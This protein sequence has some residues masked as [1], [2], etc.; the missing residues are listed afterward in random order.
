MLLRE[1]T[2]DLVTNYDDKN[3]HK[4]HNSYNDEIHTIGFEHLQSERFYKLLML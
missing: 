4:I 1:L 2:T 3:K